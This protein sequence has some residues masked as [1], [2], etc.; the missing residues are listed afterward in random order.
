MR[1]H[2]FHRKIVSKKKIFKRP[3]GKCNER[4]D[5]HSCV[6]G[7]LRQQSTPRDDSRNPR[8]KGIDGGDEGQQQRERAED[9]HYIFSVERRLGLG[10]VV[11]FKSELK[12]ALKIDIKTVKYLDLLSAFTIPAGHVI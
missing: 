10:L 3:N 5:S 6:V 12:L 8:T 11:E 4:E 7:A 2:I 9:I 1:R